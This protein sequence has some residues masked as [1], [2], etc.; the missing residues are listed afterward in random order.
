MLFSNIFD[1]FLDIQFDCDF[2]S[3]TIINNLQNY[4]ILLVALFV[5]GVVVLLSETVVVLSTGF[6]P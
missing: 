4:D 5:P 3:N 2:D 6:F 1:H